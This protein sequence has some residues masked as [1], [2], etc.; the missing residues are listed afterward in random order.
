MTSWSGTSILPVSPVLTSIKGTTSLPATLIQILGVS[1][2]SLVPLSSTPNDSLSPVESFL[3]MSVLHSNLTVIFH[4]YGLA[5]AADS[6][7][8]LSFFQSIIN[9]R[10][11]F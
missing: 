9:I 3:K 2:N 8:P 7:F 11:I 10:L 5:I 6:A 4:L 1:L